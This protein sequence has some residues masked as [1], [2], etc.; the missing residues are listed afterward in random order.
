MGP[1][2][3]GRQFY[4]IVPLR[5]LTVSNSP[6]LATAK[7]LEAACKNPGS[8]LEK[9]CKKVALL[10]LMFYVHKWVGLGA[11]LGEQRAQAG[12]NC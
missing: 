6:G 5:S 1:G 2:H 4:F 12:P 10:E 7:T 11:K 9:P 3:R 8:G